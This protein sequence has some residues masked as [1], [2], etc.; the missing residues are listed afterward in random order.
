M[1][2]ATV[3]CGLIRFSTS[4]LP[5][6]DRL[7]AWR[8][9]WVRGTVNC[10]VEVGSDLP[11]HA[12][13]ELLVWPDL[14]ALWSKESPMRYWRSR[15]QAAD[16]DDSL[17]FLIRQDGTSSVSQRGRDVSLTKGDGVGFLGGEPASAAVSEV[18][19]LSLVTSRTALAPLIGNDVTGKAMRV[20]PSH[21]EALRLLTNYAGILRQGSAPTTPELRHLVSIHIHD[22][23][24]MALGATR[25]GLAIA[26]GRGLRAARLRAIKADILANLG[27]SDLTV[28]A[29]ALRQRV[30]PRY[31]QMLFQ[32]EG[33]TFSEFVLGQRLTRVYQG[34]RDPRFRG[35]SISSIAFT[36]GF[37][38]LSYFNRTFRR[39]FGMSP[40]ELR[41]A[42]LA[43]VS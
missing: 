32:A 35:T 31:V 11:F 13:A 27:N 8:E 15:G 9:F 34:L 2:S 22:L 25:D 37:G 42:N 12:E 16:G 29:V 26:E 10:D 24:A 18:E 39:R 43:L 1:H 17:V 28:N 20:I 33:V 7:P 21:C 30:T 5:E 36:A 23:I 6:R 38:E 14:R 4:D 41:S 19:C 40:S 3:D